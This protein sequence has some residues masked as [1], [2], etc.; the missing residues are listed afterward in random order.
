MT[1]PQRILMVN[2]PFAGH[3]FP[4]LELARSLAEAGHQVGYVHSPDWQE[5]IEATG[6]HFIAY[7]D[8]PGTLRPPQ[9]DIH[10]WQAAFKTLMRIGSGYG[11]LI[12]EALF[13][14]GKAAADRIGIPSFRIFSTF[15][16]NDHILKELGRTGAG[17]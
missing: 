12:Y 3:T 15:A 10:S 4:T 5:R 7:D 13:F 11:C 16:L 17:I 8:Y 6:T 2:L 14:P 1:G 9:R